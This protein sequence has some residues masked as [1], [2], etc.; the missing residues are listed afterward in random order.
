MVFF[1]SIFIRLLL[2]GFCKM[3]SFRERIQGTQSKISALME[4]IKLINQHGLP[5][6]ELFLS[7]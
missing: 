7:L 6:T 4:R 3:Q 2:F 5:G 1:F